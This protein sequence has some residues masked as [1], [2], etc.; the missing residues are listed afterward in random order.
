MVRHDVKKPGG[1]P[2]HKNK[3]MTG[4]K[5]PQNLIFNRGLIRNPDAFAKKCG[6]A[7]W[8]YL[9]GT[10]FDS[11][12]GGMSYDLVLTAVPY[13]VNVIS[14]PP[15]VLDLKL[16]QR[17]VE[18]LDNLPRPTLI[19]C[20]MGPRA[21]AVAYM[22]AG[23]KQGA[24]PEDVLATADKDSAPFCRFPEYKEWVKTSIEALGDNTI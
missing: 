1:I 15:R 16:A 14:D 7:S 21:S 3:N 2:L 12:E 20:R 6:C 22:Y 11:M 4:F 23:L 5:L 18:A 19:S 9:N 10:E 24:A 8:L 13:S 17:H